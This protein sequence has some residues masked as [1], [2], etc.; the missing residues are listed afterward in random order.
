MSDVLSDDLVNVL[1][2]VDYTNLV[3]FYSIRNVF[4]PMALKIVEDLNLEIHDDTDAICYYI[5]RK[6]ALEF[7]IQLP[8]NIVLKPLNDSHVAKANSAWP[9][10]YEGSDQF[11]AYSIRYHLNLGLFNE[12]DELL[13]WSLRYDN[14]SIGV[15]QVDE[16]HLRKGYGSLIAKALSRK[17][18]EEF[19]CDITALIKYDN[20]GSISMFSKLGFKAADRYSWFVFKTK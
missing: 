17:I 20:V 16:N 1:K 12:A 4:R 15:L 2:E 8:P 9:H 19:D 14:G 3:D 13:A 11:I 5:P 18:A 7:K 10:R 6:A